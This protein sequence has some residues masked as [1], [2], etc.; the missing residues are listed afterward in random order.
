MACM[1]HG[2]MPPRKLLQV[3]R[4][5]WSFNLF[6]SQWREGSESWVCWK[7][8]S[9]YVRLGSLM[10]YVRQIARAIG[11]GYWAGRTW[12]QKYYEILHTLSTELVCN[13][14]Q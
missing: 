2:W 6:G 1:Q 13:S 14:E 3:V 9:E 5:A 10:T 12:P 8:R 11:M 7:S 4:H